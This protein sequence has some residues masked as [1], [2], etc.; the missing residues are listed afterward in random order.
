MKI[1]LTKRS[2]TDGTL[3]TVS[4]AQ[5][6][7]YHFKHGFIGEELIADVDGV[8]TV[9]TLARPNKEGFPTVMTTRSLPRHVRLPRVGRPV[10]AEISEL[11]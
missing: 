4:L 7:D 10:Y 5:L 8:A 11:R 3:V 6:N 2:K 1:K 9:F